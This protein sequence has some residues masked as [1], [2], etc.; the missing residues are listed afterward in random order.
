MKPRATQPKYKIV[1]QH[2]KELY[3]RFH[4][5]EI[6]LQRLSKQLSFLLQIENKLEFYS[7]L[8]IILLH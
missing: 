2:M 3:E 8:L 7:F 4:N 1:E 6:H 5:K